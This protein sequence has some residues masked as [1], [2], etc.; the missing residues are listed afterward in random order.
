M[1]RWI[2]PWWNERPEQTSQS[3]FRVKPRRGET[4]LL[5]RPQE[6][7]GTVFASTVVCSWTDRAESAS[8]RTGTVLEALRGEGGR[9]APSLWRF[10]PVACFSRPFVGTRDS[11]LAGAFRPVLFLKDTGPELVVYCACPRCPCA[12]QFRRG[13]R[14][15]TRFRVSDPIGLGR[16]RPPDSK[17]PQ[18]CPNQSGVGGGGEHAETWKRLRGRGLRQAQGSPVRGRGWG[19][20]GRVDLKSKTSS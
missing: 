18:P 16:K 19:Y 1:A 13:C 4:S 17:L 6:G 20:P 10:A 3:L 2:E 12:N 14:G 15:G 5:C 8:P 9:K 11:P 7:R